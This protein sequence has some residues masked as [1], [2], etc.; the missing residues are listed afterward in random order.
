[1]TKPPL[2]PSKE[3][4]TLEG[5]ALGDFSKSETKGDGKKY[6]KYYLYVAKK[7][8][9]ISNEKSVAQYLGLPRPF[10]F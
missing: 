7:Y 9:F 10:Q 4:W 8:A 5:K 3:H 2:H 1:M 6:Y